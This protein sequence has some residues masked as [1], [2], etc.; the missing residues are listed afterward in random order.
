MT[1]ISVEEPSPYLVALLNEKHII[2]FIQKDSLFCFLMILFWYSLRR[3]F[4]PKTHFVL[5]HLAN[6]DFFFPLLAFQIVPKQAR[7]VLFNTFKGSEH[8][9][10]IWN[11]NPQL[12]L[13][14]YGYSNLNFFFFKA[15]IAV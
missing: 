7:L 12:W 1:I 5:S 4:T 11:K 9:L 14:L 6:I 2:A 8:P 3:Y 13:A 10:A 15:S